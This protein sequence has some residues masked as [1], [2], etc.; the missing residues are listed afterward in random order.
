MLQRRKFSEKFSITDEAICRC[1]VSLRH[2]A[3]TCRLVCVGHY[4]FMT[5][6]FY[7]MVEFGNLLKTLPILFCDLYA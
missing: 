3:A 5:E 6:E 1:H 4:D 2:V 7:F